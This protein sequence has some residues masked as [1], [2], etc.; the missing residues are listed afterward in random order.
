MR[1]RAGTSGFSYDEWRG[2]F[3]PQDLPAREML[4]YY[5]EHLSAVEINNTFY[6]LPAEKMLRQWSEQVPAGFTF[7]LKASQR[8]THQKRLKDAGEPLSYLLTTSTVLGQRLGA[9]LFQL[10]PNLKKDVAR[11]RDFLALLPDGIRAAFEFRHVSWF[12]DETYA[13]LRARNAALCIADTLDGTTP[14][15]STADWGY[16]RLRREEYSDPD[17]GA[18]AARIQARDWADAF[19]FFK[20]ED[21]GTGPRLARRFVAH[22]DGTA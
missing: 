14:V 18:W 10:P 5:A 4:R 3:Y 13:E 22:F 6:R 2:S 12:D 17:L 19:V 1:L 7:V 21:A 20:H 15:E 9:L 8:I 16:L 11:L